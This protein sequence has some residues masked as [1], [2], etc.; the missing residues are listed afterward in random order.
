M[1]VR[2]P[3]MQR[4]KPNLCAVSKEQKHEGQIEQSRIESMSIGDEDCPGHC[5]DAL[6]DDRPRRHIDE[7]RSKQRECDTDAPEN[8][9]FPR[10]FERLWRSINP[11]HEDCR[12]GC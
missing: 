3:G 9:I 2:Q 10:S 4:S 11:D 6:A 7:Y 1:R 12:K 5:V 8:E